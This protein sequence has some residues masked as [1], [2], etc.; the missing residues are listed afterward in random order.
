MCVYLFQTNPNIHLHK[1]VWNGINYPEETQR[2][3]VG[4]LKMLCI[5]S[6]GAWG[7]C[8]SPDMGSEIPED[9]LRGPWRVNSCAALLGEQNSWTCGLSLKLVKKI[10]VPFA[11][12]YF[13]GSLARFSHSLKSSAVLQGCSCSAGLTRLEQWACP[14][15][16]NCWAVTL[17]GSV[18]IKPYLKVWKKLVMLWNK[19]SKLKQDAGVWM[20]QQRVG[21]ELDP[22]EQ[23]SR[24]GQ[25][26]CSFSCS[27]SVLLLH[28]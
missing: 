7:W 28:Q 19:S 6:R 9:S 5:Q 21:W 12:N 25:L 17:E 8:V 16:W 2:C 22:V 23:N 20:A 3:R 18:W 13:L 4:G 15:E 1:C 27:E 11:K 14:G 10:L 26:S 24:A